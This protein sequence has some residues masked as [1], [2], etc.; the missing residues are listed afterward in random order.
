MLTFEK[1]EQIAD[2]FSD[3]F[4][5]F[6]VNLKLSGD[7]FLIFEK[8]IFSSSMDEKWNIF[9]YN[10]FLC[11]ARSGTNYCIYKIKILKQTGFVLLEKGFVT[12]DKMQYNGSNIRQDKDI[13]L[14][15][16]QF[17]LG[18][19]DIYVAPELSFELIKDAISQYDP[20]NACSKSIGHN[21]VGL[22]RKIYEGLTTD[23]SKDFFKINGWVDFKNNIS[24]KDENEPLLSL[25]LHNRQTNSGTTFY[26][27]KEAKTF[28]GRIV[29]EAKL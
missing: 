13:L 17:R 27:D 10:G 28:F 8:G 3:R 1:Q 5:T 25:H 11:F 29:T 21:S 14:R 23:T 9:I 4:E 15:M 18:R 12:R 16:V 24:A 22:T 20:C 19:D 6:D 26:F 7:E 2:S